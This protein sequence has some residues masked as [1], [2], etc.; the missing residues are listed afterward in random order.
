[1]EKWSVISCRFSVFD[2]EDEPSGSDSNEL[3]DLSQ[4]VD[5]SIGQ[6]RKNMNYRKF[7][8]IRKELLKLAKLEAHQAVKLLV[9]FLHLQVKI[10]PRLR[11]IAKILPVLIIIFA[12]TSEAIA[13]LQPRQAEIKIN[14][15]AILVAQKNEEDTRSEPQTID[16]SV[17]AKRSPFD[18]QKPVENGYVSQ[19]YRSYHP[20]WD[21][22][23]GFN[24]PIKP[25]GPGVVSFAGRV[26]D[27]KGNV[28][29]IDHGDNLKSL[30]A[31]MNKIMVGAGDMVNSTT[32]VG[33]VGLTGRTTGP[34][35]HLE[36][37]DQDVTINPGS[38]L[39]DEPLNA[40]RLT[41]NAESDSTNAEFKH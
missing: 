4:S 27:G 16:Q 11:L 24:S 40:K 34:H 7:K 13:Y 23:T 28:V 15:Q 2:S 3:S 39:P 10:R 35:V 36:I 30:Y 8:K 37:Y 33:T 41:T 1:M 9:A 22:A 21:I 12:L 18:F 29:V 6:E 25:L 31:H 26:S 17:E 32:T 20:A 38:V 14:G 19:G 5:Q